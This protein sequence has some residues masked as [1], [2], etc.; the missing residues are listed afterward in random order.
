MYVEWNVKSFSLQRSF[1]HLV[2]LVV[3]L[4]QQINL[5][6]WQRIQQLQ[7]ARQHFECEHLLTIFLGLRVRL[8]GVRLQAQLKKYRRVSSHL[9]LLK[10]AIP[11]VSTCYTSLF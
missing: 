2:P 7:T 10:I 11:I 1:P 8:V 5:V 9:F 4:D 6:R 3:R